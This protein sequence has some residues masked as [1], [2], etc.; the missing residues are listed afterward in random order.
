MGEIKNAPEYNSLLLENQKD[1]YHSE[2]VMDIPVWFSE[3]ILHSL[4][5]FLSETHFDAGSVSFR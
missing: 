5:H 3:D 1:I 2:L 4:R